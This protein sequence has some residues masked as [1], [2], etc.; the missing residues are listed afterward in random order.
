MKSLPLLFLLILLINAC[1][2]PEKATFV[3]PDSNNLIWKEFPVNSS[4][5]AIEVLD[6]NTVWYAGSKGQIGYT[7]NGG[8]T[9]IVDSLQM[10]TLNL[11]FRSIVS[12]KNMVFILSVGSPALLFKS[13]D[14][15]KNWDLVYRE[16]HPKAFYDA[17]TFWDSLN[18]IAIGDP[19]DGCLSII[20]TRDGGNS[21]SKLACDQLPAAAEGEAA[22][23]ASN[24]NVVTFG[25]HVWIVSGGTKARVFASE[26]KGHTWSVYDTPIDQGGTMTGIFSADFYNE[27]EGI[28]YGGNWEDKAAYQKSKARTKDGGK[29]WNLI[30][31]KPGYMSC[32]QYIP[33]TKGKGILAV[34]SEGIAVSKDGG[35][36]WDSISDKG[37]YSIRIGKNGAYAWLSGNK[38]IGFL[39]WE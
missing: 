34:G 6:E 2:V 7:E 18:G 24:T 26:D 3:F 38:K 8:N 17:M 12:V 35:D 31:E 23:A 22:F 14:K 19:T 13:A 5:R 21:W 28:I 11:E 29:T 20:I 16:N 9:W 32:V 4:V 39:K 36:T 25:D 33:E 27:K 15:G 30:D 10:D 37:Y 1:D